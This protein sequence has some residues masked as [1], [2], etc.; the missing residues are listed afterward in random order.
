MARRVIAK[1]LFPMS[2]A[3]EFR[4]APADDKKSQYSRI[5][6]T[7]QLEI[8]RAVYQRRYFVRQRRRGC[9]PFLRSYS[10]RVSAALR[11][12]G[13]FYLNICALRKYPVHRRKL[14]KKLP[15]PIIRSN[16]PPSS[17]RDYQSR[18]DTIRVSSILFFTFVF[19]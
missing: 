10:I 14:F 9:S 1:S 2:T 5:I 15:P 16:F 18:R 17:N 13:A 6:Y 12:R 19:E 8:R 3:R 7:C 4:P 11:Y